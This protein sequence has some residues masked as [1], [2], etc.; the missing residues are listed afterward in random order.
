MYYDIINQILSNHDIMVHF[1]ALI[2]I[3]YD[4]PVTYH[5]CRNLLGKAR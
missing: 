5:C 2:L 4:I 3:N 1:I